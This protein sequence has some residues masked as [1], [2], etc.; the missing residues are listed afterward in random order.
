MFFRK[1]I[2]ELVKKYNLDFH[3]ASN[4]HKLIEWCANNPER[5]PSSESKDI[6]EKKLGMWCHARRTEYKKGT[7]LVER[8]EALNAINFPWAPREEEFQSNLA[9]LEEW[10]AN[11]PE[12]WPTSVSKDIEERKLGIWC[13]SRRKEYK[14]DALLVERREALNAINFPWSL[15]N[16]P[17]D[18]D[19]SKL[20]T[21]ENDG[22][23]LPNLSKNKKTDSNKQKIIYQQYAD[24]IN[25][26]TFG[27]LLWNLK[28]GEK[29]NKQ[30]SN[31]TKQRAV[32]LTRNFYSGG[33]GYLLNTFL[34]NGLLHIAEYAPSKGTT[35]SIYKSNPE[36]DGSLKGKIAR[37]IKYLNSEMVQADKRSQYIKTEAEKLLEQILINLPD[38]NT[39]DQEEANRIA[40]LLKK[41]HYYFN[42]WLITKFLMNNVQRVWL[43]NTAVKTFE[44]FNKELSILLR[45][46]EDNINENQLQLVHL[47]QDELLTY[48]YVYH[49][50]LELKIN[51][52]QYAEDL[53]IIDLFVEDYYARYF[54]EQDFNA[55]EYFNTIKQRRDDFQ[56][57]VTKYLTKLIKK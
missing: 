53:E 24:L 27:G 10:R 7:L 23:I 35:F 3:F 5:W 40:Y 46:A 4:Y 32:N 9:R 51:N 41:E 45:T 6:E 22:N 29:I 49:N 8:I 56:E 38:E 39:L 47:L 36:D 18:I 34:D 16:P 15:R 31:N 1:Q 25:R 11:N 14:K 37:L 33:L 55:D 17:E 54:E 42:S 50:Y 12:R 30:G 20:K 19:I 2:A 28:Y 43:F 44:I 13:K 52:G 48:L 21:S 26:S 57:L